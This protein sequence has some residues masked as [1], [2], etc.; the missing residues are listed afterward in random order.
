M[1]F[2]NGLQETRDYDANGRLMCQQL[3]D[4]PPRCYQYDANGNLI[5]RNEAATSADYGYDPLDRLAQE[6]RANDSQ[7]YGYDGN[8]NRLSKTGT[9]LSQSYAYESGSN[10]LI[11]ID[12]QALS[13][14]AAGNTLSDNQGRRFEY[15]QQG[16]L[17]KV[18]QSR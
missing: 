1:T 16:R 7:G 10:R 15:N 14:D 12:T 17:S 13:L 9:S 5:N 6:A 2:G 11:G 18:Y 4:L 8:G 3:G